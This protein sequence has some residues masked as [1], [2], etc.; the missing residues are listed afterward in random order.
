MKEVKNVLGRR[1]KLDTLAEATLGRKKTGHGLE[2]IVWWRNGER[3]KVKSY[4]MEDVKITKK[5]YD[6]AILNKHLKYLEGTRVK[7]IPLDTSKWEEENEKAVA[8][9]LPF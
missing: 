3:E 7:E 9:M 6:Y 8:Q 1:I 2:A 4:C 5:L